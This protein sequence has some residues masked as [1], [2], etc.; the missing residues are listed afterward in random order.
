MTNFCA[1]YRPNLRFLSLCAIALSLPACVSLAPEQQSPDIVAEMPERFAYETQGNEY[2]PEAWWVRFQ[3]P[4]L[5][6]LIDSALSKNFDIAQSIARLEQVRAQAQISR[7]ALFPSVDATITASE[8][9]NPLAGSA[10]GDLGGGAI[11]RIENQTV[12]PSVSAAYE[13]DLFS[14]NRNDAGAAR[15]DAVASEHDL[16]AVRLATA[17]DTIST[18]FEIVNTRRQIE[19]TVQ[20]ASVLND[21]VESAEEEFR[22]GLTE[23]FELYQIRQQLRATQAS[24]P[25]LESAL[26]DAENRLGVLLGVYPGDLDETLA[27]PLTPRLVF[28]PVPAGLPAQLLERR[29]DIAASWAR[30]DAARLRIGARRAERFPQISLSG[31]YGAQGDTLSSGFDF[32]DNW[33]RSLAASIVAPIFNAGRISANIRVARA[34]YDENAAAYSATVLQAFREVDSAFADYEEQRR[35]YLLVTA[36]LREAELSLDLQRRRYASGVGTYT[37]YLDGLTT[38]YQVRSD[39]SSS[40]QA[41]ALA[42]LTVHRALAGDW[43]ANEDTPSTQSIP[44]PE[45][46]DE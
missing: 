1:K 37:A 20:S 22:R 12:A 39:L 24:L 30:L 35:R 46:P 8:A 31:S 17:A 3:D 34:Q 40:A 38:V 42:R 43:I 45:T 33:T 29:P 9:S 26:A 5:N 44:T 21:R 4:V 23:S 25:Q 32:A 6:E 13:L 36:Q 11:T 7:S 41:T 27:R 18:Y 19:L 28:E 10:F 16:Q 15:L 14:R 2:K